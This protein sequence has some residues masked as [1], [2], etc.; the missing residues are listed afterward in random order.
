MAIGQF[1]DFVKNFTFF[2]KFFICS[3]SYLG[4][5]GRKDKG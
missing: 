5:Q 1:V 3:V 4:R 2:S